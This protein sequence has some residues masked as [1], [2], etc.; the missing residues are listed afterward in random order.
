MKLADS[1]AYAP[2]LFRADRAAA[3]VAMSEAMFLR[4]VDEGKMPAP[5]RLGSM[6][7]WDRLELD[8]KCDSLR[9]AGEEENSVHAIL[10]GQK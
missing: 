2:R 8:A 7:F 10:R 6:T 1:I 9:L 5:V 3:Y 4:L